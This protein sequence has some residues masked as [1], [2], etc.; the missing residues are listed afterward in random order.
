M[1]KPDDHVVAYITDYY[2]GCLIEELDKNYD[3]LADAIHP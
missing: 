2:E 3:I 1:G